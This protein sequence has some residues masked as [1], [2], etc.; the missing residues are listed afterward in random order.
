MITLNEIR[1]V[2]DQTADQFPFLI[3]LLLLSG[4]AAYFWGELL[5]KRRELQ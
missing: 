3:S 1:V 4:V 2:L 5:R